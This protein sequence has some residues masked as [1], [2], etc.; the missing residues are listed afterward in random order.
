MVRKNPITLTLIN[1]ET[2]I[3]DDGN[4]F[5]EYHYSYVGRNGETRYKTVKRKYSKNHL[6]V[7]KLMPQ[8][9]LI[10]LIYQ[11]KVNKII[12]IYIFNQFK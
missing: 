7:D 3:D 12:K 8:K 9:C 1:K 10:L 2:K 4:T 6:Q 11:Y 5:Y